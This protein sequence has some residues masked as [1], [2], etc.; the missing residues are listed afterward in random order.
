MPQDIKTVIRDNVRALLGLE[1]GVS[2]VQSLINKGVSNGN[3]QRVLGG[4]A[5]VGIDTIAQVAAALKVKPWQLLVPGLD[6]DNLPST[7]TQ[8]FRWPFRRIDPDQVLGL[9]GSVAAAVETGLLVALASA[10]VSPRKRNGTN[11]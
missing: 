4:V 8:E 10:G 3:A 6:P 2:W 1:E 5:S 9:V 7:D 11:G